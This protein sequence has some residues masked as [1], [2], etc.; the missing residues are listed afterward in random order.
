MQQ[1]CMHSENLSKFSPDKKQ[2]CH[3]QQFFHPI[4]SLFYFILNYWKYCML[5]K[6]NSKHFSLCDPFFVFI[7]FFFWAILENCCNLL[8]KN[9]LVQVGTSRNTVMYAS[10]HYM[11]YTCKIAL[12]VKKKNRSL[13]KPIQFGYDL[14]CKF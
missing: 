12:D 14:N 10:Y 9:D 4:F 13:K 3:N 8:V 7:A 6:L 5:S 11:M 1:W 2:F